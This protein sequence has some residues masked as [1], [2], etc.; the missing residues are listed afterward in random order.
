MSLEKMHV[1]I[2]I[3]PARSQISTLDIQARRT[4]LGSLDASARDVPAA[5][6]AERACHYRQSCAQNLGVPASVPRAIH[7]WLEEAGWE[8]TGAL[9]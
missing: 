3:P 8:D 5:A 2:N 6:V 7:C 4:P 1:R 9:L